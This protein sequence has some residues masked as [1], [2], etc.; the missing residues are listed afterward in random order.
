[1]V[2]DAEH[3]MD[4]VNPAQR[5][6]A[7]ARRALV[8]FPVARVTEVGAAGALQDIAADRRHVAQLGAGGELQAL[9]HDG[10][11]APDRFIVRHV[12]HAGQGPEPEAT[13]AGL[14]L[15]VAGLERVDV[16]QGGR[17]HHVQLHQ[18]DEG[19]AAGEICRRAVGTLVGCARAG[20]R[21]LDGRR[22]AGALLKGERAHQVLPISVLAWFT[23]ATMFG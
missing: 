8:A 22:I 1:M 23:A 17:P 2:G 5:R 13:R 19:G 3:R 9:R 7:A 6:T 21:R 16:H 15:A 11:L 20:R 4:A 18:V 14:D 12:G 10:E